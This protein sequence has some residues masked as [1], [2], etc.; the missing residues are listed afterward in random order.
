MINDLRERK[1]DDEDSE[2]VVMLRKDIVKLGMRCLEYVVRGDRKHLPR[3]RF[4]SGEIW[5]RV[6]S[7]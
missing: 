7:S 4:Q 2:K 6:R 1:R 5:T 3:S